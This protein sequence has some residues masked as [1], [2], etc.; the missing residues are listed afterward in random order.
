VASLSGSE[1]AKQ[2]LRLILETLRGECTIPDACAQLGVGESRFHALRHQWLQESL[3]LLEPRPL[4]RRPQ[5][6]QT[7]SEMDELQAEVQQLR[8]QLHL[9]AVRREVATVLGGQSTP[10]S[11]IKKTRGRPPR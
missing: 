3:E 8:Q 7:T 5:S 6:P 11:E 10:S 4:G 1:R 9:A 2:R